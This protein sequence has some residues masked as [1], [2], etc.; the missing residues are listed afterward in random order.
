MHFWNL[1]SSSICDGAPP[2]LVATKGHPSEKLC[3]CIELDWLCHEEANVD[4]R[5]RSLGHRFQARARGIEAKKTEGHRTASIEPM[6]MMD[7]SVAVANR[8]AIG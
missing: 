3:F 2:S 7:R 1:Q 5:L 8:K 6:E 4:C